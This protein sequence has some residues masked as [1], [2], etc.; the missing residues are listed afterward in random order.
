MK[1]FLFLAIAALLGGTSTLRE[2]RDRQDRAA[3]DHLAAASAAE[4]KTKPKDAAAQYQLAL[5]DSF[6][7]EVAIEQHDKPHAFAAAEAGID[8]AERAVDLNPNSAEYH[9]TLGTLCG[10]AISSAGLAGLRHGKCALE[11]VDKAIALDPKSSDVWLS[12][13][14][15]MYYL[16]EAFGGGV[17]KAI[18]DFR[19]ATALNPD[20]ADAWLWLGIAL[21]KHNEED[22]AHKAIEKSVQL[23][24][25]RLWAK[26]QLAKTPAK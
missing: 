26:Q 8:A 23:N 22:E 9:R 13:G 16:P 5:V 6:V 1:A 14:V 17:D 7:A 20:S 10:Q 12:H 18:S 25:A 24:P 11:E 2:A 3:L 15:G 21:R 4:A 19:K